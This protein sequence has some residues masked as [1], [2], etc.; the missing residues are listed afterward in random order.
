[1]IDHF[2]KKWLKHSRTKNPQKTSQIETQFQASTRKEK[3]EMIYSTC[4]KFMCE[5]LQ[6]ET[7]LLTVFLFI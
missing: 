1:M 3:S 4:E 7:S 6:S 5:V 2:R